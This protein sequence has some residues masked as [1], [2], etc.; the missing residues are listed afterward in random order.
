MTPLALALTP[1]IGIR[2]LQALLTHRD[3]SP[4]AVEEVLGLEIGTAYRKVLREQTAEKELEQAAKLGA[5]IVGYWDEAYPE[6]LRHLESPPTLL[7]L[8]GEL[9]P[10]GRNIGV[11][12]TRKAS[13]WALS[14][15]HKVSRELAEAGL[16]VISGLALGIDT[17]SHRGALE[18]GG[19]TLG[20]L[21]SALDKFYPAQNRLLADSMSVLSEFP[22]GTSPQAG[23][24][25]RRNRIVAALSKAV[26]VVEAGEKSGSLITARHALELG[27]DVLAVPGRPGD[28][29]SLG[30]NRLIQDGAG[31]V[32]D[33][34]DIL[35]AFGI[36]APK[37]EAVQLEGLEAKLYKA[38]LEMPESLPD[39][40]ALTV[41]SGPAETL[42]TLML[43]QLKGLVQELRGGRYSPV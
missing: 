40:L 35:S 33:T 17:A 20:V 11:V 32:M 42:S 4:E 15:T 18:G 3:H 14:W 19:Y 37:R 38:L 39:D 30:C 26:L 25:P 16:G 31:L 7:Y 22:L 13:Q 34:A 9:P 1:N 2:R 41:G 21:G 43:L 36:S 6:T 24:F 10:T 5:R 27:R 29:G 28:T 12:G 23:L 8:K